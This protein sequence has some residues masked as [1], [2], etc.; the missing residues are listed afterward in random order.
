MRSSAPFPRGCTRTTPGA[1]RNVG[2]V[3]VHP[4]CSGGETPPS[5]R[6]GGCKQR[7]SSR[8]CTGRELPLSLPSQ[9]RLGEVFFPD[10]VSLCHYLGR[11]RA[12]SSRLA[13]PFGRGG[14]AQSCCP[15]GQLGPSTGTLP[16]WLLCSVQ[17]YKADPCPGEPASFTPALGSVL[18]G[19]RDSAAAGWTHSQGQSAFYTQLLPAD[20][21]CTDTRGQ[22]GSVPRSVLELNLKA[23][24]HCSA[25]AEP[26]SAQPG[27]PAAG[28]PVRAQ[29][30]PLDSPQP[31]R[32][33]GSAGPRHPPSS[34]LPALDA[35]TGH[36]VIGDGHN[37]SA[38]ASLPKPE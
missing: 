35:A 4:C 7:K 6:G 13:T 11:R 31:Q 26:G 21:T 34:S 1:C 3:P 32:G 20:F 22:T 12:G 18:A 23:L 36:R 27:D 16:A 5:R 10:L 28:F 17:G 19:L 30:L 9:G 8:L 37:P 38:A 33:P 14:Q 24:S 25:G 29:L 15:P 2:W